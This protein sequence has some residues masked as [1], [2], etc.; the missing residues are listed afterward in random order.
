MA[1]KFNIKGVLIGN[2]FLMPTQ[3]ILSYAPFMYSKK[4]ITFSQ[5]VESYAA[6]F[7]S[8][9][10]HYMGQTDFAI[11]FYEMIYPIQAGQGDKIFSCFDITKPCHFQ[12]C[13][14]YNPLYTFINQRTVRMALGVSESYS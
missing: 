12:G 14:D 13:V 3:Q 2:P 8:G 5:Y 1:T 4:K 10:F 6:S 9:M 11:M 7:L